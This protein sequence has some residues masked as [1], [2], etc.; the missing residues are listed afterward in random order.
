MLLG[1][2]KSDSQCGFVLLFG[3]LKY[4][5]PVAS[6]PSLHTALGVLQGIRA[7]VKYKL[8]RDHLKGLVINVQ[9]VGNVGHHLCALLH[10]EGAILRVCDT[11]QD[12]V[13]KAVEQFKAQPVA[14]DEIYGLDGDVFA[15]CAMGGVL[16][17]DTINQLK[18]SIVAG[19]ANSQLAHR[20]YA[21]MLNDKNILYAPD[22]VINSGGLINAA[23]VYDYQNAE[24]AAKHIDALYDH[25]IKIFEQAEQQNKT[26]LAIAFATTQQHLELAKRNK[27]ATVKDVLETV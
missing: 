18:V 25:L 4:F 11:H 27:I 2:S 15:P 10:H 22:F 5:N 26:T 20:K 7:S 9:G 16:N 14:I 24:I 17:Y 19:S 23:Y 8:Q 21:S 12:H 13:Q 1:C 3:L 6:D